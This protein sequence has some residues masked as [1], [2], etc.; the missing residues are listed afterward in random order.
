MSPPSKNKPSWWQSRLFRAWFI[1]LP[2]RWRRYIPPKRGLT[3]NGLK[4]FIPLNIELLITVAV[5][6]TNQTENEWVCISVISFSMFICIYEIGLYIS[7]HSQQNSSKMTHYL[8][9]AA[10]IYAHLHVNRI[11]FSHPRLA[12]ATNLSTAY[13]CCCSYHLPGTVG[14]RIY[15]VFNFMLGSGMVVT[16]GRS[17]EI[18]RAGYQLKFEIL[19][20]TGLSS[21]SETLRLKS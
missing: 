21:A 1:R 5:R 4:D 6:K 19:L 18:Q 11:S 13:A 2:W 10:Y 3:F 14:S 7:H 16:Y 12:A 20:Y 9:R 8:M 17:T 15:S